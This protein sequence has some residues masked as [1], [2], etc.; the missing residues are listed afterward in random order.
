MF[1]ISQIFLLNNLPFELKT[2]II[3]GFPKPI[4]FKK[5]ELIYSKEKFSNALAFVI[6]GS[7][8]AVSN[9]Q[10]KIHLQTF[11]EGMC[12]G[13]GALFN[14]EKEYISSVFAKTNTKILFLEE[15]FLKNLFLNY[16]Q[17]SIN[18]IE[19]LTEKVRFLNKKL[20][21]ISC[22][23]ADDTLYNYL[24]GISNSE[25]FAVIPTSMTIL[26]KTLGISRASL[27]RALDNLI[28]SGKIIKKN[29]EI[30]VIKNEKN[31]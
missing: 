26:A 6:S 14:N 25:N 28:Q 17:V 7:A 18:Y 16:P 23:D 30:K 4:L 22:N 5:G 1:E 24:C 19:F 2:D 11:C 20:S 31:S 13:A 29:N 12:F 15:E 8:F 27:Y 3:K 21:I 9:N 10:N